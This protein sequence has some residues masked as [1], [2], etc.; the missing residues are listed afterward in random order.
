MCKNPHL[1][2]FNPNLIIRLL[3]TNINFTFADYIFQQIKGTAMG[4]AFSPT[5]ANIYMS[6]L[7]RNFLATQTTTP[8]IFKRYIDDIFLI[9]NDTQT[10]LNR[11]LSNLNY[12]HHSLKFTHEHSEL[13]INFLDLKIYKGS[14]FSYTNILDTCTY[15]KAQ[16]LYQYLDFTSTHPLRVFKALIRGECIGYARTNTT[17]EMFIATV[18]VFKTRLYKRNYPKPLVEKS[19]YPVSFL[20]KKTI[21]ASK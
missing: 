16:N 3:H 18:N 12:F 8:L 21:P 6:S 20:K 9:W 7:I 15:Q 5:I 17:E 13:S 4:A 19:V 10:T 2:P 11:F 14:A 1:L